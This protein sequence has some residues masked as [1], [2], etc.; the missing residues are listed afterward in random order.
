MSIAG[1][2][3]R[4]LGG[5][6]NSDSA[7][8]APVALIDTTLKSEV[9]V[10]ILMQASQGPEWV[11][12]EADVLA[13]VQEA[14]FAVGIKGGGG[15]EE[16]VPMRKLKSFYDR[17]RSRE[18]Q[19]SAST[20]AGA[21]C[22]VDSEGGGASGGESMAKRL[23]SA[24]APPVKQPLPHRRWKKGC[25]C[26]GNF[27]QN[28]QQGISEDTF[29]ELMQNGFVVVDALRGDDV[30][31]AQELLDIPLRCAPPH[32]PHAVAAGAH[33]LN[34]C[35]FVFVVHVVNVQVKC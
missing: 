29:Q 35:T 13:T 1:H 9:A 14:L 24:S 32:A 26:A 4:W 15:G 20:A 17:R 12:P 33:L 3:Q 19:R 34:A 18:R 23:R 6:G 22:S 10:G 25:C 31:L 30:A 11:T 5:D 8:D 28:L 16:R 7:H 27:V 21:S 2:V